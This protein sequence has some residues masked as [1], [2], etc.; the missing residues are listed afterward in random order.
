MGNILFPGNCLSVFPEIVFVFAN[1]IS[2][3]FVTCICCYHT[4]FTGKKKDENK[5]SD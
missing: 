2:L 4:H 1:K 5:C 3:S